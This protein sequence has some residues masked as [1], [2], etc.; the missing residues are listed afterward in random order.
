LA[1]FLFSCVTRKK[2]D[3]KFPAI[4]TTE[5]VFRD[6]TIIKEKTNFD[7]IIQLTKE[8][9]RDTL[10]FHDSETQ[11]KIKYLQ[12]PGDSIFLSAD[13]PADTVTITKEITT[14]NV[15]TRFSSISDGPVKWFIFVLLFCA[16]FISIGYFIKQIRKNGN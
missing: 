6:T 10:F 7:T 1:C 3:R 9:S 5:T 4:I 11:I 13:C 15:E 12:L 2:C 16:C 14:N 8:I